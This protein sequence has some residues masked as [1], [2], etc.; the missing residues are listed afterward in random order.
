MDRPATDAIQLPPPF[1][2][3]LGGKAREWGAPHHRFAFA[4]SA[5]AR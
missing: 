4:G 1:F 3:A 5:I 2:C